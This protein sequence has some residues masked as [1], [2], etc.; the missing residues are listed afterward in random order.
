MGSRLLLKPALT[1]LPIKVEA[2]LARDVLATDSTNLQAGLD[3][4]EPGS[5][6]SI[7]AAPAPAHQLCCSA[8]PAAEALSAYCR[9]YPPV[10][11]LSQPLPSCKAVQS[12]W[13]QV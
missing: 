7:V 3:Q 13:L 1:S 4:G 6:A 12:A 11:S 5:R 9:P 8:P 2:G 10:P